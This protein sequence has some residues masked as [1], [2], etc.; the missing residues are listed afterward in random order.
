MDFG[1]LPQTAGP[2]LYVEAMPGI[3]EEEFD[4]VLYTASFV[5]VPYELTVDVVWTPEP[6]TMTLLLLGGAIVLARRRRK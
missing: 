2:H 3:L 6:A 4:L 5:E 1:G